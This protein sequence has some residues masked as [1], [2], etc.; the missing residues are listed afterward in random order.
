MVEQRIRNARAGGSTP[1]VGFFVLLKRTFRWKTGGPPRGVGKEL[2]HVSGGTAP[3]KAGRQRGRAPMGS[4]ATGPGVLPA[5][6]RNSSRRLLCFFEKNVPLENRRPAKGGVGKIMAKKFKR[7]ILNNV[8][9][10]QSKILWPFY[11]ACLIALV[12][13]ISLVLI[14]NPLFDASFNSQKL[15]DSSVRGLLIAKICLGLVIAIIFCLLVY[16]AFYLSNR[17][18][19][20]YDRILKELDQMIIGGKKRPLK[21]RGEDQF[22]NEIVRRINIFLVPAG[23]AREKLIDQFVENKF[24]NK[25][26]LFKK[27]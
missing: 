6:G 7:D 10:P 22:F 3:Q 4:G 23:E 8:N 2:P 19:G 5:G 16:Y 1:L 24:K 26:S 20:A 14:E 12:C 9:R 17:I 15:A 27:P 11:I 13:V 25:D 21:V 18:L